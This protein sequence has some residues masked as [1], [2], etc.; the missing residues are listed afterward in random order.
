MAV[1]ELAVEESIKTQLIA[2]IMALEE[3]L[4]KEKEEHEET[5]N[6]V[7]K[8]TNDYENAKN[9]LRWAAYSNRKLL[10]QRQIAGQIARS[11]QK[12]LQDHLDD[13]FKTINRLRDEKYHLEEKIR[14]LENFDKDKEIERLEAA[15]SESKAK[16]VPES[17]VQ[18]RMKAEIND[19]RTMMDG[20]ILREY[21]S[22]AFYEGRINEQQAHIQDLM[23][24]QQV[25]DGQ[26]LYQQEFPELGEQYP[27][28]YDQEANGNNGWVNTYHQEQPVYIPS[29]DIQ[30]EK[31]S[32]SWQ[33]E[34]LPT[35]DQEE[36]DKQSEAADNGGNEQW[37]NVE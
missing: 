28:Q 34:N 27:G 6:Q 21:E 17:E 15:L 22:K 36:N 11:E 4:R 30:S 10:E 7:L 35:T 20:L 13:C 2:R 8:T 9:D 24:Q 5:K 29:D 19:I 31:S 14:S 3:L 37:W 16:Q 25:G 23:Q 33:V 32:G 12:Q 26:M 1:N 18:K